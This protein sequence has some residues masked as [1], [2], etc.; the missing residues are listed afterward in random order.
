MI[1]DDG[2]IVRGLGFVALHAAYL[3]EEIDNLLIILNPVETYGEERQRWSIRR[4]IDQA[5]KVLGKLDITEFPDFITD[6]RT[7]QDLFED[8]NEI[9]HGRIYADFDGSDTLKSGRRNI[10]DRRVS[11]EELYKLANE[12][13][14]FQKAVYAPKIFKVSRAIAKYLQPNVK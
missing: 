9:I 6:L 11:S 14:D 7:C 1:E 5:V 10:L 2:D 3:E 4:K 13:K 12:F 8:R